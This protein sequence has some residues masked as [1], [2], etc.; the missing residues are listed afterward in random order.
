M[1]ENLFKRREGHFLSLEI[2]KLSFLFRLAQEC[3]FG[4]A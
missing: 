2:N 4:L 3:L 1:C